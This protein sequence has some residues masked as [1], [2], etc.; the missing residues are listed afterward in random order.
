MNILD[1]ERASYVIQVG[2]WIHLKN[3][4]REIERSSKGVRDEANIDLSTAGVTGIFLGESGGKGET[5]RVLLDTEDDM[6]LMP[7]T[8]H[9]DYHSGPS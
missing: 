2:C 1:C 8:N 5:P 4:T 6:L 7:L 3:A 9:V